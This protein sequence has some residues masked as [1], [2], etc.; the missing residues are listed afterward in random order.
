LTGNGYALGFDIGGT[1]LK[2]GVVR[3]DGVIGDLT[4]DDTA[5]L[6][7]RQGILPL[8]RRHATEHLEAAGSGCAG[9]GVALPGLVEAGFG[10]RRLPGKVLGIE[11]FPLC[12]TLEGE[13]SIPVRCINDGAAATLAEWRFGAAK[14]VDDVLGM[15]LGTGVGSGV[16]V[17]GRP[18]DTSNLG[19]GVNVGHF[20]IQTGGKLCLCGNRGCAETLVSADAVAG[21]VRDALTRRV[22]SLLAERFAD[23]PASVTFAAFVEGVRAGDR[24]C[25]EIRDEFVR[26]LGALIVSAIHAYNP[27]VVVLAGGPMAAADLFLPDTQAYVDA[28]AFVFPAERRVELRRARLEAHAGVLGAA[29]LLFAEVGTAA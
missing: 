5:D 27:S 7:F 10:C 26:D 4:V 29:A 16:V 14:G 19:A 8:L 11:G 6:D 25:C 1:R 28:H 18:Y 22:P 13:F 9:I 3:Q 15:T 24:V 2:S 12:A 21:R 23:D 17:A 20:T